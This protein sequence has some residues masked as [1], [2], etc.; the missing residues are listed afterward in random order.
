[1][2]CGPRSSGSAGWS[3]H[4]PLPPLVGKGLY[5]PR[6][7]PS[8]A[9]LPPCAHHPVPCPRLRPYP[10]PSLAPHSQMSGGFPFLLS[11]QPTE[12]EQR[13]WPEPL[14]LLTPVSGASAQPAQKEAGQVTPQSPKFWTKRGS[15]SPHRGPT[16]SGAS[17]A[18]RPRN[19]QPG[20]RVKWRHLDTKQRQ[21]QMMQTHSGD[22]GGRRPGCCHHPAWTCR[23]ARL[24][25]F[26]GVARVGG[27]LLQPRCPQQAYRK[28]ASTPGPSRTSA[29]AG[30]PLH[31]PLG[32]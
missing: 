26:W 13:A 22:A 17:R 24:G 12:G 8:H 32:S 9:Q 23:V 31:C 29:Q 28:G 30:D 25:G 5:R 11:T 19:R 20:H 10:P 16:T 18:E 21:I 1:M 27:H 15:V 14:T 2:L 7:P 3:R 6:H 4:A